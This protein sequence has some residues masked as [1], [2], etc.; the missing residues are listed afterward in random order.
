[1]SGDEETGNS[2]LSS[3]T[4]SGLLVDARTPRRIPLALL[5]LGTTLLAASAVALPIAF[6]AFRGANETVDQILEILKQNYVRQLQ[7]KIASQT[8]IFYDTIRAN[9]NNL[10]IRT[11][12]ESNGSINFL[13]QLDLL[14]SYEKS[15]E[16][17]TVLQFAGMSLFTDINSVILAQP[18]IPGLICQEKANEITGRF[19]QS[20]T[21][22]NVLADSLNYSLGFIAQSYPTVSPVV[23]TPM[24]DERVTWVIFS[25][26]P[27][28]FIG[29][30]GL[31]WWQWNGAELGTRSQ[32]NPIGW[33]V[34][35]GVIS[36]FS[37]MLQSIKTTDNTGLAI[38]DRSN[39][40]LIAT[41][42]PTDTLNPASIIEIK[43]DNFG[44]VGKTYTPTEYPDPFI[45]RAAAALVKKYG[46]YT[47][48]PNTTSDTFKVDDI[49]MLYVET[50]TV[51]PEN[52]A[53]T[54][55]MMVA[56]PQNDLLGAINMSRRRIIG[57][58]IGTGLGM[59]VAAIG[60]VVAITIPIRQ[61]TRA[62][63]EA[64]KMDFSAVRNGYLH[65]KSWISELCEM[66]NVFG[67]MLS[68][69]SGA[70]ERN[71]KLLRLSIP[72][73]QRTGPAQRSNEGF[74]ESEPS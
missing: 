68:K 63:V 1:M 67:V 61:L 23:T 39:G 37:E 53:S 45:S 4:A 24:W 40:E 70:I 52:G 46:K 64:T 31:R 29:V 57:T 26:S 58:V 6:L 66:Q 21:V 44:Y 56:I 71:K 41:N 3:R 25:I 22:N 2:T 42:G 27:L 13:E 30:Y 15:I 59:A 49:G 12:L 32:G 5:L 72:T 60:L 43:S 19:C 20:L 47:Q 7:D 18:H 62:M 50:R 54:W 36:K 51:A 74:S 14:Y 28:N 33:Q 9:A 10:S 17:S 55:T 34:I 8:L 35:G 65:N 73:P 38:W 69:F 16:R 48:L 11:V